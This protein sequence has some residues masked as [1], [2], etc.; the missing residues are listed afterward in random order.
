MFVLFLSSKCVIVNGEDSS[1]EKDVNTSSIS[2]LARV[3][4]LMSQYR[5]MSTPTLLKGAATQRVCREFSS[6]ETRPSPSRMLK[7]CL[8]KRSRRSHQQ[9]R[10]METCNLTVGWQNV[11]HKGFEC[12]KLQETVGHITFSWMIWDAIQLRYVD[13]KVWFFFRLWHSSTRHGWRS[14][15]STSTCFQVAE[16]K[17]LPP[18]PAGHT[19]CV[20]DRWCT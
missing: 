12:E 8:L 20:R 9:G 7:R 1:W 6:Q 16:G 2:S 4:L 10:D 15:W 5:H 18:C 3:K 11:Y 14:G 17:R 13:L 19:T